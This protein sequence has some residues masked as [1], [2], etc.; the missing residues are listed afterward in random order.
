M[1][2][3]T[4]QDLKT[5][6]IL[7]ATPKKQQIGEILGLQALP[8]SIGLYLP[9]ELTATIMLGGLV[10]K[11]A[12]AGSGGQDKDSG[13]A[14]LFCSGLIAGEGLVGV[15][16]AILTVAGITERIN[17]SAVVPGGNIPSL[18][19]IILLTAAVYRSAV[20]SKNEKK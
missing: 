7:G 14:V 5:G 18:L 3:D 19:L 16:L 13:K 17:L 9:F 10:R 8:V 12:E 2:D 1:A 6:Y 11:Y 20:G 4:S 15:L